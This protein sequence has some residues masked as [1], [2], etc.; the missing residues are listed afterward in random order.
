MGASKRSLRLGARSGKLNRLPAPFPR[1]TTRPAHL[2]HLE[3]SA[4]ETCGD[5]R[6]RR[7]TGQTEEPRRKLAARFKLPGGVGGRTVGVDVGSGGSFQPVGRK[8]P[9][10]CVQTRR[11][12]GQSTLQ[13]EEFCSAVFPSWLPPTSL[14][15]SFFFFFPN[16]SIKWA[17]T[18]SDFLF[19][20][21]K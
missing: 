9:S 11:R 15:D 18:N 12:P 10:S 16:N 7:F 8:T 14:C 6:A 19:R 2:G 5:K 4:T 20:L 13:Q 17:G 1:E 21:S 3:T